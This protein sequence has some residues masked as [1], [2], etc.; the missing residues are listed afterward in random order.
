MNY[1]IFGGN[2]PAVSI[3]LAQGESIFTESGGL[4][5]MTPA[6]TMETNMKGGLMKGLGRMF[7][8]ESL[9]M[10][11]YTAAAPNQEITIA[12]S[13]PGEIKCL[14]IA[15]GKE[16]ICQKNAF[17]CA[18]PTVELA[19]EV[20]RNVASGLFGGEGF[21]MQRLRGNG[22][23]FI[24]IDGSLKEIT[25]APGQRIKVDTGNVAAYESTVG[26]TVETVKGFKNVLFGGEGLFLTILEG[27]GTVYLQTMTMPGFA[28]RII[29][30]LPKS[31]N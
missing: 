25:L 3:Q 26:Y 12:S 10:A 30:Y 24:E 14:Q 31:S 28:S 23:A 22:L 20:N 8:G 27:P 7:S 13:F 1:E 9:F 16:F 18:Q 19:T 6:I 2:L 4:S 5:W 17:L 15:P 29:P 11:T 21:I